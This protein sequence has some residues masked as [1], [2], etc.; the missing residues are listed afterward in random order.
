[1]KEPYSKGVANPPRLESCE[2]GRETALEALTDVYVGW[3]LRF[4]PT[5]GATSTFKAKPLYPLPFPPFPGFVTVLLRPGCRLALPAVRLELF[6][7]FL[8]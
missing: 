6:V 2:G 1:M 8:R 5:F 3:V 4:K 7:Q